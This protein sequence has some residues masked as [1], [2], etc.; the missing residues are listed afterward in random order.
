[1]RSIIECSP[2]AVGA[3]CPQLT[4]DVALIVPAV[5]F[6]GKTSD[7]R[8]QR[9]LSS[10]LPRMPA[11]MSDELDRGPHVDTSV[12]QPTP[13]TPYAAV[14]DQLADTCRR[15]S[16]AIATA[17]SRLTGGQLSLEVGESGAINSLPADDLAGPGLLVML[18]VGDSAAL[19]ALPETSALLPGWYAE[20]NAT[21]HSVLAALG[22]ELAPLILPPARAADTCRAQAVAHLGEAIARGSP[23]RD[24]MVLPLKLANGAGKAAAAWL[25][26]PALRPG[27]VFAPRARGHSSEAAKPAAIAGATTI[28]ALPSYARSLLRIKVPVIVTLAAKKQPISRI[29]ELGPGSIIQFDK[30]CE[31]ML[32]LHVAD[33]TVAE[34]EAV[35]VGD[36]FGIRVT[37]LVVPGERFKPVRR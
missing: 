25:V 2:V 7:K 12:A 15:N 22:Q 28:D 13:T 20:P 17:W 3:H 23:P 4:T 21:G 26:W 29:I 27:D 33:Q 8:A 36:K 34:G 32:D 6:A 10:P 11:P 16:A 31:E 24:V 19:V 37:S 35:K 5:K 18:Q 9:R 1:M 30:S 14:A